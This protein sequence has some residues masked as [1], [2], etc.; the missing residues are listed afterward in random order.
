[1]G[2]AV[3]ERILNSSSNLV[4]EKEGFIPLQ[5]LDEDDFSLSHRDDGVCHFFQNELCELHRVHGLSHKPIVCQLYPYTLVSTPQGIFVSHLYSCPAVVAGTGASP[6]AQREEL[7]QLFVSHGE[8]VPRINVTESQ[9]SIT[10]HKSIKWTEYLKLEQHLFEMLDGADPIGSLLRMIESLLPDDSR[11]DLSSR[12]IELTEIIKKDLRLLGSDD[13]DT[14]IPKPKTAMERECIE[15]FL[16]H[17]VH[18]KLL[19]VGRSVLSQLAVYATSMLIFLE[20]L[21]KQKR[22]KRVLHFS[23]QEL[24]HLFEYLEEH[25]LSHTGEMKNRFLTWEKQLVNA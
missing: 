5:V 21:E 12:L 11:P 14:E 1:M 4:L 25:L 18:G 7:L 24:Y 19:I 13:Y 17:Q 22:E 6:E 2:T 8:D 10:A 20:L 15:R 16:R 23:F 9:I 3:A